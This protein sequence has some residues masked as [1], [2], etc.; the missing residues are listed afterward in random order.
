MLHFSAVLRRIT[1][2]R[3]THVI[4]V[5]IALCEM[6][7]RAQIYN[8]PTP[9]N[10]VYSVAFYLLDDPHSFSTLLKAF[11]RGFRHKDGWIPPSILTKTSS[12]QSKSREGLLE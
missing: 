12:G 10:S 3:K 11:S 8:L 5:F 7:H 6:R 4:T 2:P 1:I 9:T